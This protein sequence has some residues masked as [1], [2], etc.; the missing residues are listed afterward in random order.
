MSGS[1]ILKEPNWKP[2]KNAVAKSVKKASM[3]L[4]RN[5]GGFP[6]DVALDGLM[7]A[8]ADLIREHVRTHQGKE[9]AVKHCHSMLATV[10]DSTMPES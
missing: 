5:R 8:A 10:L 9:L 4:C 7:L 1:D 3:R 6:V 2:V